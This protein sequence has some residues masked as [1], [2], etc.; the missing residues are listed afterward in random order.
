MDGHPPR[1]GVGLLVAT[2]LRRRCCFIGHSPEEVAAESEVGRYHLLPCRDVAATASL[3][4][5]VERVTQLE[6][7]VEQIA[8]APVPQILEGVVDGL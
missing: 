2:Y 8:G 1:V 3:D 4:E 7:V 6:R 5:L